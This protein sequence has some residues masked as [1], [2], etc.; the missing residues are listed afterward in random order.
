MPALGEKVPFPVWLLQQTRPYLST[1]TLS[2]MRRS[3]DGQQQQEGFAKLLLDSWA[4]ISHN[5][6]Y[7]YANLF[8]QW[9]QHKIMALIYTPTSSKCFVCKLATISGDGDAECLSHP[10]FVAR[11]IKGDLLWFVNMGA[12]DSDWSETMCRIRLKTMCGEWRLRHMLDFN[13]PWADVHHCGP[14]VWPSL[15]CE[16]GFLSR[17]FLFGNGL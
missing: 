3:M 9:V 12:F 16:L 14:I 17:F 5:A 6:K 15:C 2:T 8:F 4:S 1:P 13:H 11:R 10:S 7:N